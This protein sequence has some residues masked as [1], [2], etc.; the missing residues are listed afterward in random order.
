MTRDDIKKILGEGATEEQI[1]NLLNAFHNSNKESKEKINQLNAK[2]D[3]YSDYEDIKA[4]LNKIELENMTEQQKLEAERQEIARN[5]KESKI[6]VNSAKV[7]E[8]LAGENVDDSLIR[9]L[10]D[11]NTDNSIAR[12]NALKQ[13]LVNVRDMTAKE[14]RESMANV[15]LKPTISNVNQQD[16]VMDINKFMNLSA[17]EQEK[18]INEHPDQYNNL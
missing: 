14:T 12:A 18:F 4:K 9:S 8:I 2:I 3:S 7:K 13:T 10:V 11:D 15:D 1:T 5:L 6:I 17:E 16:E